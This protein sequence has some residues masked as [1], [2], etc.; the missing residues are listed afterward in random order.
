MTK[1]FTIRADGHYDWQDLRDV[2]TLADLHRVS[3]GRLLH[4]L[5]D[6]PY[7]PGEEIAMIRIMPEIGVPQDPIQALREH[8]PGFRGPMELL[9]GLDSSTHQKVMILAIGRMTADAWFQLPDWT[10]PKTLTPIDSVFGEEHL[11]SVPEHLEVYLTEPVD[12]GCDWFGALAR[13]QYGIAEISGFR[14]GVPASVSLG[15]RD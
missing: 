2:T 9:P 6:G 4:R 10:R 13:R 12:E 5:L 14:K 11:H 1:D 7:A 3:L 15:S 8:L